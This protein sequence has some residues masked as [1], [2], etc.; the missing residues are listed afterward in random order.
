M[1]AHDATV[2]PG[3]GKAV[4]A[5]MAA[6]EPQPAA[7]ALLRC[8]PRIPDPRQPRMRRV[9]A[10]VPI[11]PRKRSDRSRRE[12]GRQ[13]RQPGASQPGNRA[14]TMT[15][16]P[17]SQTC[18]SRGSSLTTQ[19]RSAAWSERPLRWGRHGFAVERERP[20]HKSFSNGRPLIVPGRQRTRPVLRSSSAVTRTEVT[21]AYLAIRRRAGWRPDH[22]PRSTLVRGQCTRSRRRPRPA[23]SRAPCRREAGRRTGR[24]RP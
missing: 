7:S 6:A 14:Q 1:P 2:P 12:P 3:T 5:A 18:R 20:E 19:P 8:W 11:A 10:V 4:P 24:R 22:A 13:A 15:R 9:T 16:N 21:A 17:K 23:G